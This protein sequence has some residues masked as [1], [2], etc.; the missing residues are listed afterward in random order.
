MSR[1]NGKR[2]KIEEARG[3]CW[4]MV[5]GRVVGCENICEERERERESEKESLKIHKQKHGRVEEEEEVHVGGVGL[6]GQ[7]QDIPS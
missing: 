3:C 4:E 7:T 1:D 6:T 5:M 2:V